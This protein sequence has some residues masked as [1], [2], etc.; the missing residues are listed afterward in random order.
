MTK[1]LASVSM[2]LDSGEPS[3]KQSTEKVWHSRHRLCSGRRQGP[4]ST[5]LPTFAADCEG[6]NIASGRVEAACKHVLAAR[7]KR[8]GMR[9][10]KAGSQNVLSL[11]VAWL[12]KDWDRLSA[13][14]PFSLH[15]RTRR[16]RS[17]YEQE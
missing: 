12:N 9:W 16:H 7:M 10:S 11:R 6:F 15:L 4:C 1:A 3:A 13:T 2:A 17:R 8:S 5:L 14:R